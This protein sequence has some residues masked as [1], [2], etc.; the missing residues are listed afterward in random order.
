MQV[1][2][3]VRPDAGRC[4][5]VDA[6]RC[7]CIDA[8]R[9]SGVDAGRCSGIV[10]AMT[11]SANNCFLTKNLERAH[12]TTGL[13]QKQVT[14]VLLLQNTTSGKRCLSSVEIPR[15]YCPDCPIHF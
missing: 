1:C 12:E 6:G 10:P 8:G 7:I 5:G 13:R 9:C 3:C 2:S 15:R 14:Q 11:A 4:N